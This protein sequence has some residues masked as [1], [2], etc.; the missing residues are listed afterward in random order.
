MAFK[1][2]SKK[3]DHKYKPLVTIFVTKKTELRQNSLFLC[4]EYQFCPVEQRIWSGPG[5]QDKLCEKGIKYWEKVLF[6]CL[7]EK[8]R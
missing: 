4:C 2:N 6:V 7:S 1:N 5:G 3:I 8:E